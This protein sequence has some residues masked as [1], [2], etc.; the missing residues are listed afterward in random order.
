MGWNLIR[1]KPP[2]VQS[3]L[4]WAPGQ[5]SQESMGKD[6]EGTDS[7]NEENQVQRSL[8]SK[9]DYFILNIFIFPVSMIAQQL[10]VH[11]YT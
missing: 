3:K 8:K 1:V 5:G 9:S 11:H 4:T 10:H 2:G 6:R 7:G